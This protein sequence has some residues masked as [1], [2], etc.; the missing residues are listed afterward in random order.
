MVR[1]ELAS[2]MRSSQ[3]RPGTIGSSMMVV[4]VVVV[5]IFHSGQ[6]FS[7]SSAPMPILFYKQNKIKYPREASDRRTFQLIGMRIII[8][9][10]EQMEKR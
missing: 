1:Y 9:H 7:S 5:V 4:V 2:L 10:K 8:A 6:S 3:S